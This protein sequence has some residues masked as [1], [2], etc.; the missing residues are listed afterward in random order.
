MADVRNPSAPPTTMPTDP[1]GGLDA[2]CTRVVLA[3]LPIRARGRMAGTCRWLR[4]AVADYRRTYLVRLSPGQ[5][6]EGSVSEV[7]RA[8]GA[9]KT[10]IVGL[11]ALTAGDYGAIATAQHLTYIDLTKC[12]NIADDDLLALAGAP[13]LERVALH[14]AWRVTD[15]GVRALAAAEN[16][17]G[18]HLPGSGLITD[19]GVRALAGA[20][21][22]ADI[23]LCGC[24]RVTD[25]GAQA[26]AAAPH[27]AS[28]DL[29]G[30]GLITDE[31]VRALATAPHLASIVLP[32]HVTDA[33]VRTLGAA[34]YLTKV[35]LSGC[36][37][38][39]DDGLRGLGALALV[40][41]NLAGC[42]GI[43][44]GG[45]IAA[46]AASDG[47][48]DLNLSGCRIP[49]TI[50][51]SL[52]MQSLVTVNLSGMRFVSVELAPRCRVSHLAY[53]S[54]LPE[55]YKLVVRRCYGVTDY[56]LC[57]LA[58]TPKLGLVDIT[59]SSVAGYGDSRDVAVSTLSAVVRLVS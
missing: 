56:D 22:L 19:E 44:D 48:A 27:L 42:T 15:R 17:T 55:L 41:L 14:K 25:A 51:Q 3:F 40:C 47:L 29:Y 20:P 59:G 4:E 35:G 7:V 34:P 46:L 45:V 49:S 30:C 32:E 53:L 12:R 31:G 28:I 21:R 10:L 23:N 37:A 6:L 54:R 52:Q 8:R 33:G 18:V 1:L 24:S 2:D 36:R 39:T 57:M 26:L 5:H 9:L 38:V 58:Q 11:Y 13:A 43:T 16:L 50:L